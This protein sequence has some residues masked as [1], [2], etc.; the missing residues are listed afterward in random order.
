MLREDLHRTG[1][2]VR[3][4]GRE[5][6]RQEERRPLVFVLSWIENLNTEVPCISVVCLFFRSIWWQRRDRNSDCYFSRFVLGFV[7]FLFFVLRSVGPRDHVAQNC[8]AGV[9]AVEAFG[10]FVF[11]FHSRVASNCRSSIRGFTF[12]C[13]GVGWS[14]DTRVHHYS[15]W[16]VP[17]FSVRHIGKLSH[18]SLERE[19]PL[20]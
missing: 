1:N 20:R 4:W 2:G 18:W 9:V 16:L 10:R 12:R 17:D 11:Q 6:A 15:F 13:R 3:E 14:F 7:S 19:S 5:R 8:I